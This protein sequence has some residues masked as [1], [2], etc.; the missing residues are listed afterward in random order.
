MV[1]PE[2]QLVKKSEP[3]PWNLNYYVFDCLHLTS[4]ADPDPGSGA[5]FTPGSE[6]GLFRI[7]DPGS[8]NHIFESLVKIFWVKSSIIL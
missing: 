4:V 1:E 7:S 6:I 5:L 2:P 3:E 8:L